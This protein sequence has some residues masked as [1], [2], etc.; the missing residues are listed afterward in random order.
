MHC[1]L[2]TSII[3]T[4]P[5]PPRD[6]RPRTSLIICHA[7]STTTTTGADCVALCCTVP[8]LDDG[9][10]R[11]TPPIR[12]QS[13]IRHV[14][15]SGRTRRQLVVGSRVVKCLQGASLLRQ[16]KRCLVREWANLEFRIHI[17]LRVD[18]VNIVQWMYSCTVIVGGNTRWNTWRQKYLTYLWDFKIKS[19][20]NSCS[21]FIL[22]LFT[23]YSS[24][25]SLLALPPPVH[26]TALLPSSLPPV[27]RLSPFSISLH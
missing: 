3:V 18:Y 12:R 26:S 23:I 20:P 17:F 25:S 10:H 1:I 14:T 19:I 7:I 13:S 9:L 16:R 22:F 2:N 15:W 24:S 6:Q 5:P 8:E 27:P 11:V 21:L 4:W